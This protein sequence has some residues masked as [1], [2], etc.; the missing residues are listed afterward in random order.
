MDRRTFLISAG[1]MLL[2]KPARARGIVRIGLLLPLSGPEALRGRLAH[3]AALLAVAEINRTLAPTGRV[4]EARVEDT[5]SEPRKFAAALQR[6][7]WEDRPASVFALPPGG[8]RAEAGLFLDRYDG[9][10]WDGAA[11][12]GGSCGKNVIHGGPTPHQNLKHIVA[13]M[14]ERHGPRLLVAAG[15]DELGRELARVCHRML[16]RLGLTAMASPSDPAEAVARAGNADAILSTMGGAAAIELVRRH[17]AAGLKA[18]IASPTLTE[19]EV[20][21]L[22]P[23]AAGHIAVQPYFPGWVSPANWRFLDRMRRR[24]G[25]SVA[26]GAAAE[27]L[28]TQIHL[29]GEALVRL[30]EGDVHPLNIREAAKD[31]VF[32]APQGKVTVEAETLHTGLW[33]KLATIG[34]TGRFTPFAWPR[35]A[36]PALPYWGYPGQVCTDGGLRNVAEEISHSSRNT[37]ADWSE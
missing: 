16:K 25:G 8:V 13:W 20:A 11:N 22:G 7:M 2:A 30:E 23:A 9:L 18:P 10:M 27:A 4:I 19:L 5:R 34:G 15:R 31:L 1:A 17:R 33:P 29:F 26:P 21:A 28:W 3:G 12:P 35:D 36:V 32:E 24:H 37:Q 6:M 14:A